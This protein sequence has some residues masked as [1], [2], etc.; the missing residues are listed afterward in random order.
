[1]IEMIR[2][3]HFRALHKVGSRP[4]GLPQKLEAKFVARGWAK[5]I[6][7][8]ASEISPA[9]VSPQPDPVPIVEP[10]IHTETERTDATDPAPGDEENPSGEGSDDP[11][12]PPADPKPEAFACEPCGKKFKNAAGLAS[13]NSTKHS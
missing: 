7:P 10:E 12:A 3:V 13:H 5:Y 8:P 6:T 1:M 9:P 2:T 4:K 11:S